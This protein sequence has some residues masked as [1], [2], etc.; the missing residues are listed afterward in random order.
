MTGMYGLD[1]LYLE[2]LG[3]LNLGTLGEIKWEKLILRETRCIL[4]KILHNDGSTSRVKRFF[5][6]KFL[7]FFSKAR[8]PKLPN[9]PFRLSSA[10]GKHLN[11]LSKVEKTDP[12]R[13]PPPPLIETR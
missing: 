6:F 10:K 1:H 12:T 13:T 11:R 2:R 8:R 3:N 9:P 7:Y 4:L 5:S